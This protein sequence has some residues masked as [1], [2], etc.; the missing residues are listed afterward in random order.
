MQRWAAIAITLRTRSRSSIFLRA[1]CI[2]SAAFYLARPLF[3][4]TFVGTS[5][6]P[7]SFWIQLDRRFWLARGLDG[8]PTS[9]IRNFM[10]RRPLF[11]GESKFRR[12]TASLYTRT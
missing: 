1:D 9:L 12:N 6:I 8:S 10:A 5:L 11:H 4:Y 7:G 3:W 2:S